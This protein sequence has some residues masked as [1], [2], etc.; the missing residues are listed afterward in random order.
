MYKRY[1]FFLATLFFISQLLNAADLKL[2][3]VLGS[4]MVLQQQGSAAVWGWAE[5]GATVSVKASWLG[6]AGLT[7]ANN[8]GKWKISLL[9]PKAG[10]PYEIIISADTTFILKDVM[11][12]EVWVCSG[13][14]NMEMP[15]KGY[16]SQ[17]VTGSTDCI[18]HGSDKNIRLFTVKRQI[19]PV[20]LDDCEGSWSVSTPADVANFS[21]VGYFF[22]KYIQGILG[23]PVG[24]IH[25]SWGGTKVEAWTDEATLHKDFKEIDLTELKTGKIHQNSPTALFNGMVNPILNYGIR[26]VIWYQGESNRKTPE[27]YARLFPAMIMD[28]RGRWNQGKFPFYFVQIAPYKYDSVVNSAFLREAQ[29]KSMLN[30]PN[31]GM[32]VT[33]DIGDYD[34]IHP[35]DKIPVGKRL[36]YWA[37]AK[38]Y[39]IKG[40]PYC[41]PVFKEMNVEG[42]KATLTFDFAESGFTSFEKPLDGFT[43][44]GADKIF[45][46]AQAT[47]KKN[48]LIVWCDEVESPI[49]VRYCWENYIVGTLFN[50]AGLPAS[51]FRTDNWNE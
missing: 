40:I 18:A 11:I 49:A 45:H 27:L 29:L 5:A 8:D 51:S 15:V 31:T 33:M 36:A 24:L 32:A 42:G 23:V 22:G 17:P 50:T 25:S 43:V 35:A 28:W 41:G 44:A 14:S 4:H 20:P 6:T 39:G 7:T 37:L 19:S 1:L 16:R 34:Y 38:T 21:A 13:Q 47:I 9:T 3:S 30:T 46:P 12:G 10:G 26:G 48:N 2:P